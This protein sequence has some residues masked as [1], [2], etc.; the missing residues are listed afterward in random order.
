[1]TRTRLR[2]LLALMA[3]VFCPIAH[4]ADANPVD[5]TTYETILIPLNLYSP[6]NPLLGGHGSRWATSLHVYN[7]HSDEVLMNQGGPWCPLPGGCP[8]ESG[9]AAIAGGFLGELESESTAGI[10]GSLQH[11]ERLYSNKVRLQLRLFD[12][13]RIDKNLGTEV[14]V[15]RESSFVR[16]RLALLS[17]PVEDGARV[18]VRIY[19]PSGGVE[20]QMFRVRMYS[21]EGTE[22]LY[23]AN[24]LI[25]A[26]ASPIHPEF[27][28]FPGY[29][30]LFGIETL[31][32]LA[33]HGSIRIEILPPDNALAYWA[34]ASVTNDVTQMVTI[35]SPQ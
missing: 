16:G 19:V 15:V 35:V 6:S 21:E 12:L 10:E 26:F 31:P 2:T 33:G 25:T 18:S 34:M 27:P 11:V 1:M 17:V 23:E 20:G 22:P 8:T 4:A 32:E 5:S 24:V 13:S 28:P 14:P 9:F 30:A 29:A 3:I 7:L